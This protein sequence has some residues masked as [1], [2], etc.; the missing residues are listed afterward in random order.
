M[1]PKPFIEDLLHRVDIV[2]V[3]DRH[4]KLKRAGANFV[5]CCPFHSEKSPSFTVSQTKQFY[6]CF[7][8]GAHGTAIGFLM[9]FSGLGFVE[10]IKELAQNVGLSVP[11]ERRA[12]GEPP[13]RH[14][15][16]GEA[17]EDLYAMMLTAAQFYRG[18]LREAPHA[19]E[20]LKQRGLSGEIAKK[21]GVG[22]APEG[23]QNLERAF[24][25]YQSKALLTLGLAKQSE[26]GRRFD[27]FRDR[28]MF[29]IIDVKGNVIG[30]GGRV[31]GQGE[32]KYLNS[33]ET[34]LF[35]KGRELYGLYQARRAIR[36][37]GR[38]IVVE[39]YMDVVA[40]AQHGVEYA[41][42]TLG[43]ATTPAHVQKLLRQTDE[44]VYCFDGDNAGRRA[45]WRA[46]EN[47]LAQLADGKQIKFLFLPQ[48]EDPDTYVR[49]YGKQAFEKQLREAL[50]L[51]Q[52]LLNEL[53]SRGD[54]DTSEGRARLLQEAKPLLKQIAAPMLS[55]MLRKQ[56]ADVAGITQAELDHEF[57]IQSVAKPGWGAKAPPIVKRES[58]MSPPQRLVT[59]LLGN[60]A[61]CNRVS[62]EQ[63]AM[64]AGAADYAAALELIHYVQTTEQP[65]V[66]AFLETA[67]DSPRRALFENAAARILHDVWDADAAEHDIQRIL[68]GVE[69]QKVLADYR[70]LMQ[71][72]LT[73]EA[74]KDQW[75]R[76][77]RRL[78][79]FKGVSAKAGAGG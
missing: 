28:I 66:A 26:E 20:Y 23:W 6:H 72:P 47:S 32:P 58:V 25:N 54:R 48:G 31:L 63:A 45:A 65:S 68:L 49:Q 21:F 40:L 36:D 55:L 75:R 15:G 74:E 56:L 39:G 30:F 69:E 61:L 42:A 62:D 71:K 33:P 73:T 4:V 46:L 41:V 13:Q 78:A 18:A 3:I 16:E 8:C 38:V 2:D 57:Q 44:I 7:G 24:D 14:R 59:L 34:P 53:S 27:L 29:P 52:F 43:T 17:G 9:E 1:I 77:S 76:L 22:Y 19:I 50:P 12:D 67:R 5:A 79:E 60:L 64:L 51:S 35:E 10:A 11:E 37:A 70:R